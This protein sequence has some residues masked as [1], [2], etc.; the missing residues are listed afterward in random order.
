MWLPLSLS[1]LGSET[2]TGTY[3][4]LESS[5]F[6]ARWISCS[7]YLGGEGTFLSHAILMKTFVGIGV[8]VVDLTQKPGTGD[9]ETES[10]IQA[11]EAVYIRCDGH[12]SFGEWSGLR[13]QLGKF[14]RFLWGLFLEVLVVRELL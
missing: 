13:N 2:T 11:Y 5:P 3:H 7:L 6:I 8:I 9:K 12:G 1:C 4:A 14:S 10:D